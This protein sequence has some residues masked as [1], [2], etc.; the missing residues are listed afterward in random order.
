MGYIRL[1][2]QRFCLLELAYYVSGAFM[3]WVE[4]SRK[5]QGAMMVGWAK[6]RFMLSIHH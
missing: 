6:Y 1:P 2:L 4:V 3:L 5:D